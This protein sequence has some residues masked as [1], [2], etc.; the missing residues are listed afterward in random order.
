M[1]VCTQDIPAQL[2]LKSPCILVIQAGCKKACTVCSY[3]LVTDT[4]LKKHV[5][6]KDRHYAP[7]Q[8]ER[9]E[10]QCVMETGGSEGRYST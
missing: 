10:K 9:G 2:A 5:N 3:T 1:Q 4:Q 7:G 8:G 6:Y